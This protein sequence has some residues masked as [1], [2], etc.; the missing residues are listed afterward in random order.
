MVDGD[1]AEARLAALENSS[2]SSQTRS[3]RAS[4]RVGPHDA[5]IKRR[6]ERN[7]QMQSSKLD[8][9][10]PVTTDFRQHMFALARYRSEK[11]VDAK[12]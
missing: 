5:F 10:F 4:C 9:T 7:E 11:S 12:F 2:A 1:V 6:S 3:P 8:D